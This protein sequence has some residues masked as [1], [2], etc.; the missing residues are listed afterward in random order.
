[1]KKAAIRLNPEGVDNAL[2][3]DVCSALKKVNIEPFFFKSDSYLQGEYEFCNDDELLKSC[4]VVIALGGD[5]TILHA[6]KQAAQYHK[7]VLG[8]NC[9]R[10]GFLAGLETDE[11]DMLELLNSGEYVIEKR[12]M[13][14][15]KVSG[16]NGEKT[17][18]CANDAV[19][20]RGSVSRII[21]VY[22]GF[23]SGATVKYRCDG[24][25]A[26]TPTGSTAYSLSAGGPVVDP[27]INGYVLTP[28]CA[29]SLISRPIV[30]G[31][32]TV[33]TL[34]AQMRNGTECYLTIDGEDNVKICK[35]DKI[36]ISY[37]SEH[38]IELIKMKKE[39][40][41][42]VLHKKMHEYQ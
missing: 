1:M 8:I 12:M 37:S 28:V 13:L 11:L 42:N 5:G 36:E 34:F 3:A 25:I 6:A 33:I 39:N 2:V 20:S 9:G 23:S 26:S 35:D 27:S 10:L 30:L 29:H 31:D 41:L 40:F 18:Y 21:D 17:A 19:L 7:A 14:K 32:N 16:S 22:V 15:A 38:Y 24:I 4:D